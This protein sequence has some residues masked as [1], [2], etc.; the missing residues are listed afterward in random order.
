[1][2]KL[3]YPLQYAGISLDGPTLFYVDQD[4]TPLQL[5]ITNA[6]VQRVLD[7]LNAEEDDEDEIGNDG[8]P[9]KFKSPMSFGRENEND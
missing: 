9:Y 2:S 5:T 6:H 4:G 1:M 3:N 7:D 8:V